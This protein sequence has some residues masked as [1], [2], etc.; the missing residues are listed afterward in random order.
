[1]QTLSTTASCGFCGL[2]SATLK[3]CM[4]C[5][6]IHYC[7]RDCQLQHRKAHRDDCRRISKKREEEA[8]LVALLK[9]AV[10]K[11]TDDDS[12][13]MYLP[14][15]DLPGDNASCWIC[16]EEG[17]DEHGMRIRR[18]CAC[19]GDFAGWAHP[20]C[21]AQ[22]CRSKAESNTGI[23]EWESWLACPLCKTS[24]RHFMGLALRGAFLQSLSGAPRSDFI[25][26]R[27]KLELASCLVD[28]AHQ[29]RR[30]GTIECAISQGDYRRS[31]Y[32]IE[33]A[34]SDIEVA[35]ID[36]VELGFTNMSNAMLLEQLAL[37]NTLFDDPETSLDNHVR[38]LTIAQEAVTI[39][40]VDPT[41][42]VSIII[43]AMSSIEELTGEKA[44]R[45]VENE[46][47]IDL[48]RDEVSAVVE[49]LG[50]ACDR[51]YGLK[52][53]LCELLARCERFGER[54]KLWHQSSRALPRLWARITRRRQG[55]G[56]ASVS[57]KRRPSATKPMMDMNL[58]ERGRRNRR[59]L[60]NGNI[61]VVP[62][63]KGRLMAAK[64]MTNMTLIEGTVIDFDVLDIS[65]HV[66][67]NMY[68][69]INLIF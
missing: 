45:I 13:Y 16:L 37:V 11:P 66:L 39:P 40:G 28:E 38:A 68:V 21:L 57:F 58:I 49:R 29:L 2:Q 59:D 53:V 52:N 26:H 56:A 36:G 46:Y 15:G 8:A 62:S 30:E 61:Y 22:Y 48:L 43:S 63:I 24:Y 35:G 44:P 50:E 65:L 19:R 9:D 34:I 12:P 20:F 41:A 1:M 64:L 31:K 23:G 4:G 47:F 60:F 69:A 55:I 42:V 3:K 5:R 17:P 14:D 32:L 25:L 10:E 51:V 18:G 33:E 67:L 27:A 7:G 6:A 54:P